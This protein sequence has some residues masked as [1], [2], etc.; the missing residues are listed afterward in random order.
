VAVAAISRV[1]PLLMAE[2][3]QQGKH[4]HA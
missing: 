2:G 1:F 3:G 4:P